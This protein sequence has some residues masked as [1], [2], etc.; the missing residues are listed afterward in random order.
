[1]TKPSLAWDLLT[2]ILC[3]ASMLLGFVIGNARGVWGWGGEYD[4][5]QWAQP[6]YTIQSEVSIPRA[7]PG[8]SVWVQESGVDGTS[9]Y[10]LVDPCGR[11]VSLSVLSR[12]GQK[13]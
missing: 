2:A 5:P 1:M 8:F 3:L 9:T 6:P 4:H 11:P 7:R 12:G 10:I 13:D